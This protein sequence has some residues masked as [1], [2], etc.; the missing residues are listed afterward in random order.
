LG[1]YQVRLNLRQLA[2]SAQAVEGRTLSFS[3]PFAEN[4]HEFLELCQ[5]FLNDCFSLLCKQQF[6]E[7]QTQIVVEEVQAIV[8]LVSLGIDGRITGL[9]QQT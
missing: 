7:R 1:G 8:R 4:T 6:N 9:A 2:L 3:F 5:A